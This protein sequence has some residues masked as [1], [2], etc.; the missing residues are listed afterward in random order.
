MALSG[1]PEPNE[2][3][4]KKIMRVINEEPS[5]FCCA[6]PRFMM[7]PKMHQRCVEV[8]RWSEGQ[9]MN[10][11]VPNKRGFVLVHPQRGVYVGRTQDF[12]FWSKLDAAGRDAVA[13][14]ESEAT[15]RIHVAVWD[16]AQHTQGMEDE[17]FCYPVTVDVPGGWA[18]VAALR[19][20][21]LD[22]HLGELF[23]PGWGNPAGNC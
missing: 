17:F 10:K 20:A 16:S 18:S 5:I 9:V 13:T 2:R 15:A 11:T 19:A 22:E 14:F 6:T 8:T 1:G 23:H 21:G 12:T 3:L 4:K 7:L